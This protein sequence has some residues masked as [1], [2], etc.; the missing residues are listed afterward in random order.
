MRSPAGQVR[1]RQREWA[2]S[3]GVAFDDQ[4]YTLNLEDNL[5]VPL[6]NASMKEFEQGDGAELP[7]D[8]ERGKMQALH[9][10]SAL[11]CNVFEYWRQRDPAPLAEALGLTESIAEIRFEQKYRTGLPGNAP[12]LDVILALTSGRIIAIE[13]KFL[14][15]YGRHPAQF[16]PKYFEGGRAYWKSAGLKCCQDLAHQIQGAE[17][18]F[19]WLHAQQLLKHALGLARSGHEW[20]LWYAWHEVEG[21]QG[22]EH[23]AEAA[24]FGEM[25]DLDGIGFRSMTYQDMFMRI[26]AV[27]T[28]QHQPYL[29]Y[30]GNRYF[31]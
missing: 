21:T 16:N 6:S 23:A 4:G 30:L 17:R 19:R 26:R 24:K 20:A 22:A 12:N 27:C 9:S 11:A 1:A 25:L 28:T 8:G 29:D 3:Q 7:R 18:N 10:S 5:Y 14:E 13:S 31:A 2:R 15:P